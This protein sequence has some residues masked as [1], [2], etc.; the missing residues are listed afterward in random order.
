MIR[1]M[2]M[3]AGPSSSGKSTWLNALVEAWPDHFEKIKSMTTR[4][5][6]GPE[7]DEH[8]FVD[9]GTFDLLNRVGQMAEQDVH[10][11]HHYGVSWEM[12]HVVWEKGK[13][14]VMALNIAGVN[15]WIFLARQNKIEW[16]LL[17]MECPA[18]TL[19]QR[20]TDRLIEIGEQT[21]ELPKQDTV[22]LLECIKRQGEFEPNAHQYIDYDDRPVKSATGQVNRYMSIYTGL[23]TL[24]SAQ[25]D[26]P[27]KLGY[28]LLTDLGAIQLD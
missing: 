26:L 15:N 13:V 6:R 1:S 20:L 24:P 14:P 3:I 5:K 17:Y 11:G 10:N 19:V 18:D 21:L 22:R 25:N 28:D 9:K 27:G 4:P 16:R 7:D 8:L 23:D 2:L 12:L